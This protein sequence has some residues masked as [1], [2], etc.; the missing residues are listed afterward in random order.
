[1]L[2][3]TFPATLLW[4][5]KLAVLGS[6]HLVGEALARSKMMGS[7]EFVDRVAWICLERLAREGA[8][9]VGGRTRD[10]TTAAAVFDQEDGAA[11]SAP[12]AATPSPLFTAR[13]QALHTIKRILGELRA[14]HASFHSTADHDLVHGAILV[15]LRACHL[16]ILSCELA[17]SPYGW[18]L[19]RHVQDV[20][21]LCDFAGMIL[22]GITLSPQPH[23]QPLVEERP[24][25]PALWLPAHYANEAMLRALPAL[26]A[27]RAAPVAFPPSIFRGVFKLLTLRA[28][29]IS[30]KWLHT[31]LERL[32]AGYRIAAQCG[33]TLEVEQRARHEAEEGTRGEGG[34][35]TGSAAS[36][37]VAGPAAG[38]LSSAPSTSHPP[39]SFLRASVD[40]I[41][42]ERAVGISTWAERHGTEVAAPFMDPLYRIDEEISV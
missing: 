18:T 4:S 42:R 35:A 32:A 5:D 10:G 8:H 3:P 29:G 17:A 36:T 39:P 24:D 19:D 15:L 7:E 1:M 6:I 13:R 41:M 11:P 34:S 12:T 38:L 2:T 33:E 28:Q 31:N 22:S 16:A 40:E 25:A 9:R 21:F 14:T 30:N 26:D 27:M 20:V 23:H 37:E